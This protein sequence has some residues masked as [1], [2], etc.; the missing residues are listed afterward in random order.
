MNYIDI[1]EIHS[2]QSKLIN[3]YENATHSFKSVQE[4]IYGIRK[5]S[6]K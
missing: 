5:Y 4:N 1:Y 6:N 2:L 3:I